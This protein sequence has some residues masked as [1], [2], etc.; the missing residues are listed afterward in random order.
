MSKDNEQAVYPAAFI[1]WIEEE[2]SYSILEECWFCD[3]EKFDTIE[4]L[5]Q[6]YLEDM[7]NE[8]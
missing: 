1:R 8:Y 7:E 2:T 4:S 5:Y 6:H 3:D